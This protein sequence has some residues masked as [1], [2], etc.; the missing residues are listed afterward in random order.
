MISIRSVIRTSRNV[1]NKC[2]FK[3][4]RASPLPHS[5][6]RGYSVGVTAFRPIPQRSNISKSGLCPS[7]VASMAAKGFDNCH[8]IS[9]DSRSDPVR[10]KWVSIISLPSL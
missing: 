2:P 5:V 6:K 10:L 1:K 4:F 9:R 3:G 8:L 7:T